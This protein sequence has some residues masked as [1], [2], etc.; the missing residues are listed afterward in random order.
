MKSTLSFYA[1]VLILFLFPGCTRIVDWAKDSFY[2]G[3]A[4]CYDMSVPK[5]YI[6]SMTV[7]DEFDTRGRFDILWLSDQVRT[8]YVHLYNVKHGNLSDEN[9]TFLRRQLTE[10]EHVITFYVIVP[11]SY[12]LADP[13]TEWS[14]FLQIGDCRVYPIEIREIDPEPEYKAFLGKH[15]NRFRTAYLVRFPAKDDQGRVFL[16]GGI[17]AFTLYARSF[18]KNIMF[19]W[20]VHS[21]I[22]CG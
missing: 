12:I 17:E 1:L 13:A 2:Q 14:L 3:D 21:E 6:R 18:S 7:Y 10:N 22:G 15:F 19:V 4:I 11:P 20:D 16:H 5:Y 8:A 9:N